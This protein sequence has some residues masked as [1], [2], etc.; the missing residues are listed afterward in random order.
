MQKKLELSSGGW[1]PCSTGF[2]LLVS[3]L[4]THPYQCTSW[5][6]CE[7][8]PS[9]SVNFFWRLIQCV[10]ALHDGW[11][12]CTP[13]HTS[14]SAQQFLTKNGMTLMPHPPY[15][16]V[17][18]SEKLSFVSLDENN[19]KGK[20]TFCWCGRRETKNGRITRRYQNQRL[21]NLF[22]AVEKMSW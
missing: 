1:A 21:Q 6:Y 22:W 4:G 15:S 18:T 9:V 13:A 3:V 17:F 7:R 10:C 2:P 12:M 8:L 16:P 11:V 5:H 19:L 14:L 20:G